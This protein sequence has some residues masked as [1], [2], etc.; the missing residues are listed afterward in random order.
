MK[1]PSLA[2]FQFP[3]RTVKTSG[4][5]IHTRALLELREVKPGIWGE[6]GV[7]VPEDLRLSVKLPHSPTSHGTRDREGSQWH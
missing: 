3:E 2:V 7:L 1:K 6:A 5:T 4:E